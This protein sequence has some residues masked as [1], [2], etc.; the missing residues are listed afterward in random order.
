MPLHVLF[1][2][3]FAVIAAAGASLWLLSLGGAAFMAVALPALLIAAL[4]VRRLGG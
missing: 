2:I 4:A 1:A 3:I